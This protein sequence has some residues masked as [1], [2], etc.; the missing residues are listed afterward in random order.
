MQYMKET[1]GQHQI[2]AA[3]I[4]SE[5]CEE[6]E[7]HIGYRERREKLFL[8]QVNYSI[9][10]TISKEA[11]YCG[12]ILHAKA[13]ITPTDTGYT[14]RVISKYKPTVP[15]YAL[16]QNETVVRKMIKPEEKKEIIKPEEKE[17]TKLEDKEIRKPKDKE[18]NK[19]E[20]KKIIPKEKE[21]IKKVDI[22]IQTEYVLSR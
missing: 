20:E 18:V 14:A 16:S 7:N 12:E 15:I 5:I 9:T 11:V 3:K 2:E 17:I 1:N 8:T 13:I 22:Q 10:N 6:K 4:M 21:E 19:P